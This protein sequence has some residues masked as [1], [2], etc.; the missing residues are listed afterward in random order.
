MISAGDGEGGGA[1]SGSSTGAGGD[2]G[3]VLWALAD[4][5]SETGSDGSSVRAHCGTRS[6][7]QIY[8]SLSSRVEGDEPVE[9]CAAS[10]RTIP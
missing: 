4:E 5:R 10:Y 9:T 6:T 1:S 2:E 7:P 8:V 3:R